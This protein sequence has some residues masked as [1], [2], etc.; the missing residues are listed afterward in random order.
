MKKEFFLCSIGT[1]LISLN[2]FAAIDV[3]KKN[4]GLFG[5][6]QVVETVAEGKHTLSCFDP[7]KTKCK[8]S[9]GNYVVD[10]HLTLSENEFKIIDN[11]VEESV[12]GGSLN[13]RF[14]FDNKCYVI[15]S[16]CENSDHLKFSIYSME[17]ARENGLI[18]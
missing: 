3:T 9:I 14:V 16:Y 5:Y 1:L 13:G 11:R 10:D 4:R 17:E 2:A 18:Y 8:S 12:S 7:G 15:Y 6:K